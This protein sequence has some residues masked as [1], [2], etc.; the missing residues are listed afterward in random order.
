MKECS[1]EKYE[2]ANVGI[3]C[4]L[5]KYDQRLI[6]FW[7]GKNRISQRRERERSN[8]KPHFIV[9]TWTLSIVQDDGTICECKCIS[10][11]FHRLM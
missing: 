10:L 2:W 9:G 3:V 4:S 7:L 1:Y 8:V 11:Y 5:S 6:Q